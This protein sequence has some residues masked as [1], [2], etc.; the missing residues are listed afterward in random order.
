M[1]KNPTGTLPR[2][3]LQR[4]GIAA[5]VK[6]RDWLLKNREQIQQ[7]IHRDFSKPPA[8]VDLSEIYVVLSEVKHAIKHLQG[9]I[10][11]QK[12]DSTVAMLGSK[13]YVYHEPKG[14][15]LI[16]S[17][18]NFPFNLTVGPNGVCVGCG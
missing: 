7:A 8:E 16:I 12:V 2:Y 3:H 5:L 18:W 9:W 6:I 4:T 10:K 17:P 15:C 14:V 13:S 1:H 11:P